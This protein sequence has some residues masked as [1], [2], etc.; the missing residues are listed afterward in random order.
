[1]RIL[2]TSMT[3]GL[4]MAAAIWLVAGG[5]SVSAQFG[6]GGAPTGSGPPTVAQSGVDLDPTGNSC[7]AVGTTETSL[8][9]VPLNQPFD[10]DIILRGVPEGP[11]FE[12]DGGGLY[13]VGFDL[14]YNAE[15]LQ[16]TASS[17]GANNV[18]QLCATPQVP[19]E[20]TAQRAPDLYRV[21]SVDLS[22]NEEGGDGRVFTVTVECISTGTTG[23]SLSDT[24]TGGIDT[25]GVLGDSG[26][27]AYVVAEELEAV[28]GC[29]SEIGTITPSP[30]PTPAPT[31]VP[32]PTPTATPQPTQAPTPTQA[33]TT[34][35]SG[36]TGSPTTSPTG[37]ASVTPTPRPASPAG[38]V[39]PAALPQTGGPGDGGSA[40][41]ALAL[42]AFGLVAATSWLASKRWIRR[43]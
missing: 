7:N 2:I 31:P 3:F 43:L 1:M 26:V 5:S 13:G 27:I 38:G 10:I 20:V 39:T 28:V 40:G 25:I 19:F 6:F 41:I 14:T 37:G 8:A 24:D 22:G 33:T 32:T 35:T 23:I 29:N 18:L 17:G 16:V 21:D 36:A 30:E 9:N 34:P 15:I 12:G 11:A 4:V 42:A